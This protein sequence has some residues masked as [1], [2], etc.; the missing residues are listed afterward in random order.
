MPEDKNK[1]PRGDS[2]NE[3]GH[4]E[5]TDLAKIDPVTDDTNSDVDVEASAPPDATA[6][7]PSQPGMFGR[8]PWVASLA[9]ILVII[10]A[11]MSL[12]NSQQAG[13]LQLV[14]DKAFKLN[15]QLVQEQQD[16]VQQLNSIQS[17][18]AQNNTQFKTQFETLLADLSTAQRDRFDLE[19]KIKQVSIQASANGRDPLKW[20]LA[21][22]EYLLSL[23]NHRLVLSQDHITAL[24]ALNDADKR[25]RT[26]ADPGLSQ[27]RM[28]IAKEIKSLQAVQDPDIAGMAM[29]LSALVEGIGQLPLVNR[30]RMLVYEE[31]GERQEVDSWDKIPAAIWRDLKGLVTVRRSDLSIEP[32]LPPDELHYLSQNLGLKIEQARLALLR[33]DEALFRSNLK[34]T[35]LW[36][37][38]YFDHDTVAVTAVIETINALMVTEVVATMPDISSSLRQLRRWRDSHE[39]ASYRPRAILKS[40]LKSKP[41]T[42]SKKT[43]AIKPKKVS[44]ITPV[45]VPQKPVAKIKEIKKTDIT[46]K[47][48]Q[49][50]SSITD[51]KIPPLKSATDRGLSSSAVSMQQPPIIE[52]ST[53]PH[54]AAT[55]I[56]VV[57]K[58]TTEVVAK[59]SEVAP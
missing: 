18:I 37:S 44:K 19:E 27:I 32:I 52:L 45:K 31:T 1:Q 23:A 22:I 5:S 51:G 17:N 13:Q 4:T 8:V 12:Q 24:T 42:I 50:K 11:I 30:E 59:P 47:P 29:K 36:V 16:F 49:I 35:G 10:V 14:Q 40:K 15:Q 46:L 2:E 20:R 28:T 26:I 57:T 54:K 25:L 43:Q 56:S 7:T 9:M 38:R 39:T 6:K 3:D 21:E 34:D 55:D 41:K 33:K 48:A 58:S 53:E